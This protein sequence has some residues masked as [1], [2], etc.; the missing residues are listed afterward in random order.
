MLSSLW[1]KKR[2]IAIAFFRFI[3]QFHSHTSRKMVENY[4]ETTIFQGVFAGLPR[5]CRS[6]H[7]RGIEA[8]LG[9]PYTG[10]RER[11]SAIPPLRPS[12]SPFLLPCPYSLSLSRF[13][14]LT[15]GHRPRVQMPQT[16]HSLFR[17]LISRQRARWIFSHTRN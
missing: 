15:P 5:V 8:A 17:A 16:C 13:I 11:E 14:S 2:Q 1:K 3:G 7:P 12:S 4:R 6:F 10:T 9:V